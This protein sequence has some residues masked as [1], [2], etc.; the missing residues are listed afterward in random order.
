MIHYTKGDATL[1]S[2]NTI[3][4]HICNNVRVWG[5]GFV[6]AI[7]R[8]LGPKAEH[9]YRRRADS[10]VLG[11]LQLVAIQSDFHV[12]NM[13]AQ[14]G[15][16][17]RGDKIDYDALR[18]CLKKLKNAALKHGSKIHMPRIGCGLAGSSWDKIEPLLQEI[19]GEVEIYV[20]DF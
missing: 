6:I 20:H 10:I 1:H 12:A 13:V 5:G 9:T 4:A 19:A 11:T 7:T 14:K 2:P 3:V 15:V 17:D 18:R 16:T 8:A